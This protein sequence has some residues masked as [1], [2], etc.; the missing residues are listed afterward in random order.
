MKGI[1]T[2]GTALAK[3]VLRY[4]GNSDGYERIIYSRSM[5]VALAMPPDSHIA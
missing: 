5:S 3:A 2:V 4:A 1:A